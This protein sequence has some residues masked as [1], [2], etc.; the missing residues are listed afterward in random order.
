MGGLEK[1]DRK[2]ALRACLSDPEKEISHPKIWAFRLGLINARGRFDEAMLGVRFLL[3]ENDHEAVA[4]AKILDDEN[5][6]RKRIEKELKELAMIAS[7][8]YVGGW[9]IFRLFSQKPI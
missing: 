6:E 1:G 3:A 5:T 7:K 4:F 8:S 2:A 9:P